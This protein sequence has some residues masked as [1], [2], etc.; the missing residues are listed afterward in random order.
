MDKV[1]HSRTSRQSQTYLPK[2][3]RQGVSSFL[4]VLL[5]ALVGG[6]VPSV[7]L[8]VLAGKMDWGFSLLVLLIGLS[9]GVSAR[10]IGTASVRFAW[11]GVL[12]ATVI[13]LVVHG[14]VILSV[15]QP[16]SAKRDVEPAQL[17]LAIKKYLTAQ[18]CRKRGVVVFGYDEVPAEIKAR[19]AKQLANMSTEQKVA[20]IDEIFGKRINRRGSTSSVIS[21]I[22]I[23]L[24]SLATIA[25]AVAATK[26]NIKR[27]PGFAE[28]R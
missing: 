16:W 20:M 4:K 2:R 14:L 26:I 6:A 25:L 15:K 18:I 8:G 10:L 13:S 3:G 22:R 23:V 24:L 9:A 21:K 1:V 27:I 19:A 5:V 7:G 28:R 11:S 17:D 12:I